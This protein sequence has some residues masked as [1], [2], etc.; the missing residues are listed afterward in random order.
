[1]REKRYNKQAAHTT[2]ISCSISENLLPSLY[3]SLSLSFFLILSY[4][5]LNNSPSARVTILRL[6][7]L[8]TAEENELGLDLRMY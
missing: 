6:L 2:T 4:Q 5:H 7:E 3:L 1:M 8:K